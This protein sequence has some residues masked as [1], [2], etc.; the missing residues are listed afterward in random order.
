MKNLYE[1]EDLNEVF[2]KMKDQIVSEIAEKLP[3]A[4]GLQEYKLMKNKDLKKYLS[5]SD[6]TIENLRNRGE[7]NY[8]KILGTYYYYV[9]DVNKMLDKNKTNFN[10]E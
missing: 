6:S 9:S 10:N 2:Q 8:T 3:K 1:I 5:V 4:S 7:L